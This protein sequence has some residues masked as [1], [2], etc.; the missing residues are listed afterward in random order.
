MTA[1]N[2][3]T[4][5]FHI[6]PHVRSQFRETA[7]DIIAKDRSARK[8]G[9]SQNT[10]GDIER[11]LAKAYALGHALQLGG[12]GHLGNLDVT[13]LEWVLVPPRSRQTLILMTH[14]LS[15]RLCIDISDR[16]PNDI[17]RVTEQGRTRWAIVNNGSRERHL[18]ADGSVAPLIRLG[19]IS[20]V[21]T[22]QLRYAL[23]PLGLETC[24]VY[25]RR[26]DFDD[27]TLPRESM[28]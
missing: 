15:K 16:N 6:T 19:L 3:K 9:L 10:I 22:L 5:A 23:T 1:S 20:N 18:I 21:D 24:K 12:S 25:W 7:R 4:K 14:R 27:Q 26:S 11:A 28:R 13:H 17:E 8:L 2:F